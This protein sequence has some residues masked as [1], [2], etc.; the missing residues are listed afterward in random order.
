M[1]TQGYF[2]LC[3][4]HLYNNVLWIK[5]KNEKVML[6]CELHPR[7]HCQYLNAT[8]TACLL[9]PL[10]SLG[11]K[12]LLKRLT[13]FGLSD[14]LVWL[15]CKGKW[16]GCPCYQYRGAR[17]MTAPN[18]TLVLLLRQSTPVGNCPGHLALP[19]PKQTQH[20]RSHGFS[21]DS[22][23]GVVSNFEI[24]RFWKAHNCACA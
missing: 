7:S 8:F 22:S 12:Q 19:R 14:G 2:Y 6:Y 4:Y 11:K 13:Y 20:F 3:Y 10:E 21:F 1:F 23:L 5:L 17:A 18:T 9:W 16:T 24:L 15:G